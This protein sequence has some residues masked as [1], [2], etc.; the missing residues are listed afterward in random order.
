VKEKKK[1][2]ALA[3][4]IVILP[5]TIA[6]IYYGFFA[7]DRYVSDSQV[8]VRQAGSNTGAQQV[9]GLSM[10][11]GGVNPASREETLYLRQFIDSPDM[12]AILQKQ[13]NWSA[14]YSAQWRDPLYWIGEEVP[15]EE[16][17]KYY[18]RLV[19]VRYDELTGLLTV[20]VQAF[21]PD[22]A[23]ATQKL[24]L[25]ESEK[26]VNELS[27]GMAREQMKFAESELS[28]A[29]KNYETKRELLIKFQ[30]ENN[31]LD[32]QASA[33]S[34]A[35]IV[36]ELESRITMERATLS[37]LSSQLDARSPQVQQQQN[38][39]AAL[40]KQLKFEKANLVSA[41]AGGQLNVIAANYQSLMLD[42]GIAEETYKISINAL[43]SARI[44]TSKKI[45]SLITV[46]TP[47]LP[48]GAVYPRH[49]YNLLTILIGVLLAY[50]I[51]RFIIA[52]IEDH[53][54]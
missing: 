51:A 30:N 25:L 21:S 26:F 23:L 9:P 22:F 27:Q 16:L 15:M 4:W 54:D 50:G 24:V 2:L 40:L 3:F 46:V 31:L 47:A 10:L 28:Y 36:A 1:N 12:L 17:L 7:V 41:S 19:K 52:S 32:A 53:R 8:V 14:H 18:R 43:E 20:E 42:A 44:E 45:R 5:M 11:I 49:I 39:I 13:L 48:Q 38:K 29:R 35:A 6:S 34:G 37:A 33:K